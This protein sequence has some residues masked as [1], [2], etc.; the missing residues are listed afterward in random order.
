VVS[1]DRRLRFLSV[2]RQEKLL[3]YWARDIPSSG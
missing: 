3:R 1:A 2:R